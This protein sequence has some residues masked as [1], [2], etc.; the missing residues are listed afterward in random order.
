LLLTDGITESCNSEDV[1][2]GASRAVDY[3][4]NHRQECAHDIAEGICRAARSFA[5]R[6]PQRDDFMAVVTKIL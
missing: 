6:Q 5:S 4:R 3:A 1:D 2:F